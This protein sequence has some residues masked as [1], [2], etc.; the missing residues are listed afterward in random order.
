LSEIYLEM[1]EPGTVQHDAWSLAAMVYWNLF[2]DGI[3]VVSSLAPGFLYFMRLSRV[4]AS[5]RFQTISF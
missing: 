3:F 4:C 2:L 1:S 5:I